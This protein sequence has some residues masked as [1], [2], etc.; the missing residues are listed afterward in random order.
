MSPFK[1]LLSYTGMV[2]FNLTDQEFIGFSLGSI[3][4]FVTSGLTVG[5]GKSGKA[6]RALSFPT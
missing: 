6:L 2:T 4:I 3:L 5:A 1:Y